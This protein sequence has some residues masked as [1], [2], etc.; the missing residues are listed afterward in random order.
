MRDE[1]EVVREEVESMAEGIRMLDSKLHDLRIT[2]SNLTARVNALKLDGALLRDLKA[3]VMGIHD[4]MRAER[5]EDEDDEERPVEVAWAL[6]NQLEKFREVTATVEKLHKLEV[7]NHDR[8]GLVYSK[9]NY[10]ADRMVAME[11]RMERDWVDLQGAFP[12]PEDM[13]R[14][15]LYSNGL[16]VDFQKLV[17]LLEKQGKPTS[18]PAFGAATRTFTRQDREV[19]DSDRPTADGTWSGSNRQE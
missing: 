16:R 2:V 19:I 9:V 3:T 7:E 12:S 11:R 18:D 4:K 14:L 15:L 13:K 17:A 8:L 5:D 6:T 1:K 10:I